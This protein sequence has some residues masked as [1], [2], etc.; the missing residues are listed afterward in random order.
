MSPTTRLTRLTHLTLLAAA[1]ALLAACGQEQAQAPAAANAPTAGGTLS[2]TL[3][4]VDQ[5]NQR[6]K[7]QASGVAAGQPVRGSITTTFDGQEQQWNITTLADTSRTSAGM[8]TDNGPYKGLT[9]WGEASGKTPSATGSFQ[10]EL[11]YS[12][13]LSSATP[14]QNAQAT[15]I[16]NKGFMPPHWTGS[17][18]EL[19]ITLTQAQFDGQRG[20][21][22]GSFKGE[23]CLREKASAPPDASNCKPVEGQFASDLEKEQL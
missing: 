9:L 21:I 4:Q 17:D 1:T 19:S 22:E 18:E 3:N 5:V 8:V 13:E 7:A 20:R 23:L 12:G 15:W 6:V 14:M 2:E 10:L 11:S 16:V